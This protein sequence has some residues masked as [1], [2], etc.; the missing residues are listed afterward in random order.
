MTRSAVPI[1]GR[2]DASFAGV[3]AA[4]ARNFA[5]DLDLGAGFAAFRDGEC[6]VDLIGGCADRDG[7]TPWAEDTLAC[8]YS[9]GKMV[10]ALLIARAVS[11]GVLDYAAPI[12]RDWPEF[13]AN[14]KAAITLGDVLSHQAGLSGFPDEMPPEEWLDR[15]RIEAR[16][17]ALAPLFPPR[18]ASGYSPQLFGFIVGSVLR[19]A[20]GRGVGHILRADFPDLDLHCGLRPDEIERAAFMPKPPRAPDLGPLS[21]VKSIAFLKPWSAPAKVSREAWMAAE[22]PSSNMHATARA[23]AGIAHPFAN[24]GRYGDAR[25]LDEKTIAAAT[26]QRIA[27]PDLVLPFNLAWAA[28]FMRNTNRH[29]G[30]SQTAFGHAGFGGSCVMFDPE[31]RLSAAFVMNKMSPHLVGDPRALAL[32]DALYEAL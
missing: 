32:I 30:P 9:S 2:C 16:I 31:R 10:L 3:R 21:D 24:G 5:K 28:G 11:R 7:K 25:I 13:G 4:F 18:S 29:F 19:R 15:E 20:T 6:V 22:I 1:S 8:V 26:A 27:G 23:L 17:A 14:G 12:A